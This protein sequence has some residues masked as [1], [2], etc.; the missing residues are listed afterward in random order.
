MCFFQALL[1]YSAYYAFKSFLDPHAKVLRQ[2]TFLDRLRTKE[3]ILVSEEGIN[4]LMGIAEEDAEHYIQWI[5]LPFFQKSHFKVH[6]YSDHASEKLI[7]K[8]R[9]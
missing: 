1:F 9:K 3:R 4:H 8:Y 7:F 6:R 2:K 5:R